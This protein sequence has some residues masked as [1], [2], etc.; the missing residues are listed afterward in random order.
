MCLP[1]MDGKEEVRMCCVELHSTF[2]TG[3]SKVF[4]TIK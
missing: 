4:I 3:S 2:K 1:G